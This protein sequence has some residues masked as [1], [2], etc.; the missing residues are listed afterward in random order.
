MKEKNLKYWVGVAC[1]EHVENGKKLGICQF[2]HGKSGP[3]NRPSKGDFIIYYS[4]KMKMNSH[5]IC[6]KF[7]AIGKIK[8][9][10]AYQVSM[11]ENF[12]PFRRKINYFKSTDLDIRP[13]IPTLPFIKNK[14]SWGFIFRYGFLEIDKESF[15]MIAKEM[16]QEK[17]DLTF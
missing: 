6:Q 10:K 13:L 2:C 15:K 4:S 12:K 17:P 9:D 14:K 11:N 5:E 16:L 3:A 7:T 8:D 1:R